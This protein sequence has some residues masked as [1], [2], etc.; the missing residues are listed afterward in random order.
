MDPRVEADGTTMA[1]LRAQFEFNTHVAVLSEEANELR[2]SV[3]DAIG[4]GRYSGDAL[5]ELEAIQVLMVDAGGSYPQPMLLNQI[6]Y[7][8]GMTGR[9]DQ[10][11]GNF[12]YT[13]FDELKEQLADLQS[14]F[15]QITGGE[16]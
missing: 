11:P 9:A 8:Q 6:R 15:Q 2:A 7:L 5:R 12:A 13:R 1:D 3:D 14:R 10:R 4:S 16:E